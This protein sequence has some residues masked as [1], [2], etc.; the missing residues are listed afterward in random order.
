MD[1]VGK[2]KLLSKDYD[3]NSIRLE[4]RSDIHIIL[5]GLYLLPV[6]ET[7]RLIQRNQRVSLH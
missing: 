4:M 6:R 5:N 3:R 1:T 2:L 7:F